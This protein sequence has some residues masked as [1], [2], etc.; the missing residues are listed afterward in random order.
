MEQDGEIR[1]E[2]GKSTRYCV[3]II[4]MVSPS[5][6]N[7]DGYNSEQIGKLYTLFIKTMHQ[8]LIEHGGKVLRNEGDTIRAYFPKTSIKNDFGWVKE[9]LECCLKQ[10]E[11]R[12]SLS[13]KMNDEGLPEIFYKVTADYEMLRFNWDAN[14]DWNTIPFVPLLNKISRITPANCIALGE[15]LYRSI[16]TAVSDEDR[17]KFE[18]LG[19]FPIYSPNTSRYSLYL[20]SRSQSKP[21]R[22]Y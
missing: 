13:K 9:F 12:R 11:N 19:A 1:S 14:D 4:E 7:L 2:D 22:T 5:A 8:I 3:S 18:R 10:I 20:L 16:S 17:Y 6:F 15:D 21:I